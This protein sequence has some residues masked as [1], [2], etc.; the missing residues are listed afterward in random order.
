MAF[1]AGLRIASTAVASSRGKESAAHTCV[2]CEFHVVSRAGI[3]FSNE[4]RA[5][6]LYQVAGSGNSRLQARDPTNGARRN[7]YERRGRVEEARKLRDRPSVPPKRSRAS[8]SRFDSG[9]RSIARREFS[10]SEALTRPF[11]S[12]GRTTKID[13]EINK[14]QNKIINNKA[15]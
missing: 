11:I 1:T 12:R 8:A 6:S 15:K 2:T 13:D 5:A 7:L 4:S 3:N 10:A 14:I 9:Y